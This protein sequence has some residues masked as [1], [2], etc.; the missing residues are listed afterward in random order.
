MGVCFSLCGGLD[1]PESAGQGDA[2]SLIKTDNMSTEAMM[3]SVVPPAP[4][5]NEINF[6]AIGDDDGDDEDEDLDESEVRELLADEEE[7]D[8][9]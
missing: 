8:S 5:L 9:A 1:R 2:A 3:K 7:N 6:E 4:L